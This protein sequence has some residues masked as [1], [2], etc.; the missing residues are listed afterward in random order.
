MGSDF[1]IEMSEQ[2]HIVFRCFLY[3]TN[4]TIGTREDWVT[5]TGSGKID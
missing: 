5:M 2:K 1:S 4:T 3:F